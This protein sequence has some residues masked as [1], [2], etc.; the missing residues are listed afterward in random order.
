MANVYKPLLN[1]AADWYTTVTR[2]RLQNNRRDERGQ[3][4]ALTELLPQLARSKRGQKLG[5]TA[6]MSPAS[7]RQDV[8]LSDHRTL[9][10]WIER[11]RAG[12]SN[13]LWPGKCDCFAAT[14]GTTTGTPRLVPV[15]REMQAT[16]SAGART[17]TLYATARMGGVHA[18]LGRVLLLG[19][20]VPSNQLVDEQAAAVADLATLA[21]VQH[22][23]WI[24][25]YYFEPGSRIA[26]R[27]DWD[28]YLARI[29]KRVRSRKVSMIVG[30]PHW[31]LSFKERVCQSLSNGKIRY[32][33]LRAVWSQLRCLTVV[34]DFNT[35]VY[36]KLR[37]AAGEGVQLHE[38][39]ANA[40]GIIAA[41]GPG[42]MPGLRLLA[43]TGIYYEFLPL[44]EYA[45]GDLAELGF[46]A[47]P[48][49][50]VTIGEDYLLVMT[51]PAGLVRH[52]PGDIVRFTSVRPHR[53]LPMGQVDQRLNTF[54]ENVLPRE[55]VETLTDLCR[56]RKWALSFF[57]VAPLSDRSELG[58]NHGRH[59]WWI[60]LQAGTVET[61]TGPLIARELDRRLSESHAGYRTRRQNGNLLPPVVRLV[62]PGAFAHWL[63][64]IGKWGGPHKLPPTRN[65]RRIA[66]SLSR[67]ARF[68][69]D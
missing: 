3:A 38:V 60:E 31:L 17:A 33:S 64:H 26:L 23:E 52:L 61:P 42:A 18:L 28:D 15:T 69:K 11:V 39:F 56:S 10:P 34:G 51:T 22:P 12:K 37:E 68:S 29:I 1:I 63:R 47:L 4:Q 50:K 7:F 20:S 58:V 53:L 14:A 43:D 19:G 8:P 59:E 35:P 5:L 48:F 67:M 21:A 44:R 40:E 49:E 32:T 9:A 13:Q 24:A 62:M 27:T 6:K 55:V 30:S 66:D 2:R 41:E 65:D 16:Y 45:P 54:G 25:H 46:K 57:H 36:R